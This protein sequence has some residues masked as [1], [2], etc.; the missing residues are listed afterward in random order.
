MSAKLNYSADMIARDSHR[1]HCVVCCC[2]I[3]GDV[4]CYWERVH[5]RYIGSGRIIEEFALVNVLVFFRFVIL[6]CDEFLCP[7]GI[8]RPKFL[9][10]MPVV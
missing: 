4:V 6:D 2:I 3:F 9:R 10:V 7:E 5:F 8:E 1:A